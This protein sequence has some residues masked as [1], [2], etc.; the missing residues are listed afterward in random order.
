MTIPVKVKKRI[1]TCKKELVE[2]N[3][4]TFILDFT[5][6]DMWDG[7]SK[8]VIFYN[9]GMEE[10]A[11]NPIEVFLENPCTIPWEVLQSSGNLYIT[12][13]GT[14]SDTDEVIVT[15]LM[16]NP[17]KVNVS[18]KH[19]GSP[20]TEPTPSVVT[21]IINT[22]NE[23]KK[24][25]QSV[26]DDADSGKFNGAKGE[27]GD[28]G[29]PGKDAVTDKEFSLTSQNAIANC[30]V[31]KAFANGKCKGLR[32]YNSL[33]DLRTMREELT[34]EDE[35]FVAFTTVDKVEETDSDYIGISIVSS[36]DVINL[37]ST[38]TLIAIYNLLSAKPGL[39]QLIT[40]TSSEELG[41]L[42]SNPDSFPFVAR[43]DFD[44]SQTEINLMSLNEDAD[45][46]QGDFV[47][48]YDIQTTDIIKKSTLTQIRKP[49]DL[50]AY[51]TRGKAMPRDTLMALG[52]G[53]YEVFN[54]GYIGYSATNGTIYCPKG[55]TICINVEDQAA[56][57]SGDDYYYIENIEDLEYWR[58]AFAFTWHD[59]NDSIAD[60]STT[61]EVKS[62]I[63]SSITGVLEGTG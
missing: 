18:G 55:S 1:V 30:A 24:I 39:A 58:E 6:D 23:A 28:K 21:L 32:L 60:Y 25:A 49:L 52:T 2:D 63:A 22:A 20:S 42:I 41:T 17:I 12:I 48:F 43:I 8:R 16:S 4:D 13:E 34:T 62:L 45:L 40:L 46:E 51:P 3:V 37:N 14:K 56:S 57:V 27:K 36:N 35:F 7:F 26:R 9:D 31:T 53:M 59:F 11:S 29:E 50:S 5:F 38:D 44:P 47:I 54:E 19:Q 15:Q 61:E 33:A 10:N